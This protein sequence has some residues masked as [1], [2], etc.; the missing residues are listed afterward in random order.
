MGPPPS[1]ATSPVVVVTVVKA[2]STTALKANVSS[3]KVGKTVTFKATVTLDTKQQA[4]GAMQFALDGK[5][6]ATVTVS[7]G[8]GAYVLP[9][10]TK[11]GSHR[12]VATFV[13]TA[14]GSVTGSKSSTVAVKI[15]KLVSQHPVLGRCSRRPSTG[16]SSA[17]IPHPKSILCTCASEGDPVMARPITLFTGQWADL[18]FEKVAQLAAG[19]GYDGLEIAC[20]GDHLDVWRAAE[21]PGYI[22]GRLE[23]LDRHNLKVFAI[24]NHLKG[25]AVCDDPIDARHQAI[26]PPQVWGERDC[27]GRPAARPPRR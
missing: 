25:Q 24:S 26:L 11:V 15:T 5:K 13:P 8:A 17:A 4:T 9:S 7:K 23:I 18:P 20:W 16:N 22:A 10:S 12:V 6:V 1:G 2:V 3:Q 21:E 19:W 14:P 27:R